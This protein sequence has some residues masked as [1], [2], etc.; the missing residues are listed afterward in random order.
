MAGTP[1]WSEELTL[2]ALI[3]LSSGIFTHAVLPVSAAKGALGGSSAYSNG[4][5]DFMKGNGTQAKCKSLAHYL[6]YIR[7]FPPRCLFQPNR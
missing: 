7:G 4:Y 1:L 3:L 6:A 2:A 5:R